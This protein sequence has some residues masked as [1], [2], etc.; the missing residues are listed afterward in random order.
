MQ[1]STAERDKL[2]ANFK[3][4][5]STKAIRLFVATLG[6]YS[7]CAIFLVINEF[8]TP[9]ITVTT[10]AFAFLCLVAN[11]AVLFF[12]YSS[13][14][15]QKFQKTRFYRVLLSVHVSSGI[16][17]LAAA[18]LYLCTSSSDAASAMALTALCL[19]VPTSFLLTPR[20]FGTRAIMWP[21]YLICTG[22]HAYCAFRLLL[23]P[24]EFRWVLST[25]LVLHIYVWV[26][27][28]YFLLRSLNLFS[29]SLYS[30]SI[31]IAGVT[32]FPFVFGATSPLAILA[33]CLAFIGVYRA[34]STKSEFEQLVKERP[35]DKSVCQK[36]NAALVDNKS[37]VCVKLDV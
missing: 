18:I 32:V 2:A 8:E 30:A 36:S 12:Y 25:F 15:D 7:V 11:V 14:L 35:R 17:E 27:V 13:P 9:A 20:V 33:A 24:D 29:A 23:S 31:L 10:K 22:L 16:L 26:R 37:E 6:C 19:H 4:I 28:Y 34:F 21:A 3:P 5:N 1:E